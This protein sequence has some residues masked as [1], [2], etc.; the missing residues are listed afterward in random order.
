MTRSQPSEQGKKDDPSSGEAMHKSSRGTSRDL[1][2]GVSLGMRG[3]VTE[4]E[5]GTRSQREFLVCC[6]LWYAA[7]VIK[8][9]QGGKEL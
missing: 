7:G 8:Q 3:P 2:L 6:L 4:K 5:P 1:R 9:V